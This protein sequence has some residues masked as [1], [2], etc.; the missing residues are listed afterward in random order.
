MNVQS[1][2]GRSSQQTSLRFSLLRGPHEVDL[3]NRLQEDFEHAHALS[4]LTEGLKTLTLTFGR[5]WPLTAHLDYTLVLQGDV[6]ACYAGSDGQACV[7]CPHDDVSFR[8]R[9]AAVRMNGT[10]VAEGQIP[11]LIYS[12]R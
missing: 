11:S 8:F 7:T 2:R 10:T 5:P 3:F 6:A 4:G 12:V 9:D 1:V